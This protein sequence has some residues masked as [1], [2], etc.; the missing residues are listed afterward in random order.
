MTG[1]VGEV[2]LVPPA[3]VLPLRDQ[4]VSKVVCKKTGTQEL[5]F[6]YCFMRRDEFKAAV[7]AKSHGTAQANVSVGGDTFG[8]IACAVAGFL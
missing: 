3:P 7:E 1:Y 8:S 2:G 5:G 6:V 4:R